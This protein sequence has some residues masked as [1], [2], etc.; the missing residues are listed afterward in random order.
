MISLLPLIVAGEMMLP[1]AGV[2]RLKSIRLA[3]MRTGVTSKCSGVGAVVVLLTPTS[4]FA[5]PL[6]RREAFGHAAG[7]PAA[8]V[9][10]LQTVRPLPLS[11]N[12]FGETIVSLLRV[13]LLSA[14]LI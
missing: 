14:F 3:P 5:E 9:S 8:S 12:V 2:N 7:P 10:S 6:P 4:A 11:L 1:S 13:R